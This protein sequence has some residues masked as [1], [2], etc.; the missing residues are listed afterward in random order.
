V[1][2]AVLALASSAFAVAIPTAPLDEYLCYQAKESKNPPNAAKFKDLLKQVKTNDQWEVTATNGRDNDVTKFVNICNPVL[3]GNECA[4]PIEP[5]IHLTEFAIKDKKL[6]TK[7]G[8]PA[9]VYN[10]ADC[11]GDKLGVTVSKPKSLMV[12]TSKNDYGAITKCKATSPDC[13]SLPGTTC[14]A[15]RCLPPATIPPAPGMPVNTADYMCYSVKGPKGPFG[16][17][18]P[19]TDQFNHSEAYLMNKITKICAP[20]NKLNGPTLA[21]VSDPGFGG[22]LICYQ[23]KSQKTNSVKFVAHVAG[24]NNMVLD[25]GGFY[26]EMT[27]VTDYCMPALKAIHPATAGGTP[28]ALKTTS[29][30]AGGVCG[31]LSVNLA[32]PEGVQGRE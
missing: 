2:A 27:K 31:T 15:G 4:G 16:V 26:N 1:A 5:T 19:V 22:H 29:Q 12:R 13:D 17:V 21:N 28:T 9:S 10:L 23:A 8:P 25:P 30:D 3:T 18:G 11:L 7:Y 24:I 32:A 20:T 6:Q 14:S